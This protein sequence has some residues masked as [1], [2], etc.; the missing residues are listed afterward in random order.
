MTSSQC[1]MTWVILKTLLLFFQSFPSFFKGKTWKSAF[2]QKKIDLLVSG[3]P[4][5]VASTISGGFKFLFV[6][7]PFSSLSLQIFC[8]FQAWWWHQ[9]SVRCETKNGGILRV[10]STLLEAHTVHSNSKFKE[11]LYSNLC[12]NVNKTNSVC[13]HKVWRISAAVCAEWRQTQIAVFA[14][15]T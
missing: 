15:D 13:W 1:D 4:I 8:S 11:L 7:P 3:Q 6:S 2:V 9:R 14:W 5:F 12:K 10:M